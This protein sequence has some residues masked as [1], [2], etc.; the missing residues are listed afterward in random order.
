[1]CVCHCTVAVKKS[2]I[3][4]VIQSGDEAERSKKTIQNYSTN[5]TKFNIDT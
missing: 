3:V 2:H 4:L 1:M 5:G